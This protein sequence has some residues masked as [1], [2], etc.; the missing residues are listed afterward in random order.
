VTKAK[1]AI[2]KTFQNLANHK[3]DTSKYIFIK[4]AV[5]R[6]AATGR[7]VEKKAPIADR[8]NRK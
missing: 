3:F 7:L 4:T 6:D 5:S 8:P 1:P 2:A